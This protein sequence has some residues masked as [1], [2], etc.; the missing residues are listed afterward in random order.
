[1]TGQ[2]DVA[3]AGPPLPWRQ[4]IGVRL[5]LVLL[6]LSVGFVGLSAMHDH[7]TEREAAR[8][9]LRECSQS[10]ARHGAMVCPGLL[11]ANDLPA[12]EAYVDGLVRTE[13]AVVFASVMRIADGKVVAARARDPV[14]DLTVSSVDQPILAGQ[15][16][17]RIGTL[18]LGISP[19]PMQRALRGQTWALLLRS[20]LAV[21]LIVASFWIALRHLLLRPLW[22]LGAAAQRLGNGDLEAPVGN[23]GASELGQLGRTL[24]AMRAKL[25]QDHRSLAGQNDRL[26]GLDR[27]KSQFLANTSHEM[28]TPLT[29]ILGGAEVLLEAAGPEHAEVAAAVHRY[30]EQLLDLVDRLLDLAKLESGNLLVELR[31]CRPAATCWCTARKAAARGWS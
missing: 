29:G 12:L 4:G 20:G 16:G 26:L 14:E 7:R 18:R 24:E 25:R 15:T 28:R 8:A 5:L 27:L 1:M 17:E 21:L 30:G 11:A 23:F 31:R 6:L 10:L 2:P 19:Q 22:R 3:P 13:P 9:A